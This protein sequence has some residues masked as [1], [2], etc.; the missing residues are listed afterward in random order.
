MTSCQRC[1]TLTEEDNLMFL[2]VSL[3]VSNTTASTSSGSSDTGM[4]PS[5]ASPTQNT[6]AVEC[7][8]WHAHPGPTHS[9]SITS[10]CSV[11]PPSS[12]KLRPL[13]QLS[14]HDGEKTS[15]QASLCS[16]W[17]SGWWE[18]GGHYHLTLA[19]PPQLWTDF[20]FE[21]TNETEKSAVCSAATEHFFISFLPS[22]CGPKFQNNVTGYF[23]GWGVRGHR[24][25]DFPLRWNRNR[26][27]WSSAAHYAIFFSSFSFTFFKKQK[28]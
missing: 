13:C 11:P 25:S 15:L 12:H 8:W 16:D 5:S 10:F 24:F 9:H 28:T 3:L 6:V 17:R 22:W 26:N 27:S 18:K 21:E 23:W 14:G 1:V 2:F 19:P 4:S 7:R 20:L